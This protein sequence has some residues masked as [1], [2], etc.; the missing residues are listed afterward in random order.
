M[1]YEVK[2][3][4]VTAEPDGINYKPIDAGRLWTKSSRFHG[5]Y[6]FQR[7]R[8]LAIEVGMTSCKF[9]WLLMILYI[10]VD[11][12]TKFK[13]P[14]NWDDILLLLSDSMITRFIFGQFC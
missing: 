11:Q 3:D 2:L 6:Y 7:L 10:Y 5:R 1:K 13:W 12:I 9:L 8:V 4:R 14:K